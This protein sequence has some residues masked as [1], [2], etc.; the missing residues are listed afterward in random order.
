M[1]SIKVYKATSTGKGTYQPPT[2][3]TNQNLS[4]YSL[5]SEQIAGQGGASSA[6]TTLYTVPADYTFF[7]TLLQIE[8]INANGGGLIRERGRIL[9]NGQVVIRLY[10]GATAESTESEALSF[11]IPFILHSGETIQLL[12]ESAAGLT[13]GSYAGFLVKNADLRY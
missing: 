6:T 11:G 4:I 5:N 8:V 2:S 12:S 3:I 1:K 13:Q 9:L 7:V 10:T